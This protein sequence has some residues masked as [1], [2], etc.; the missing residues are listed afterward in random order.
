MSILSWCC[1]HI[2]QFFLY[3]HTNTLVQCLH[4]KLPPRNFWY[5][6]KQNKDGHRLYSV[7]RR[8]DY[9]RLDNFPPG[10]WPSIYGHIPITS[11]INFY[12][13]P[14]DRTQL[15]EFP[16]GID[17]ESSL[18]PYKDSRPNDTSVDINARISSFDYRVWR[19]LE[20]HLGKPSY[21]D[22]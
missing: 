20:P 13:E 17:I 14:F 1:L 12:K 22:I 9:T 6:I 18:K 8:L 15:Q 19:N 16:V 3:Y 11:R 7:F 4:Y 21:L 5:D 2:W 10:I